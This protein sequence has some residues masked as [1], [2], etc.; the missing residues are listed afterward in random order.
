[1]KTDEEEEREEE[2][3]EYEEAITLSLAADAV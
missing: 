3:R 1:V 2:E